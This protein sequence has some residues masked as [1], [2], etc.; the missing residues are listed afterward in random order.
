MKQTTTQCFLACLLTFLLA[1]PQG[2]VAQMTS[3]SAYLDNASASTTVFEPGADEVTPMATTTNAPRRAHDM[4][5]SDQGGVNP[6][7]PATGSPIGAPLCLLAFAAAFG[8]VKTVR[9]SKK[10]D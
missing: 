1:L 7:T 3:T 5:E 6:G 9:N 2:S 10:Q 8:A 4:T